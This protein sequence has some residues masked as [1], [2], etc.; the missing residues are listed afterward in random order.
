MVH[1]SLQLLR[2]QAKKRCWDSSLVSTIMDATF[3]DRRWDV[4]NR[5]EIADIVDTYPVLTY[6]EEVSLYYVNLNT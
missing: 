5:L 3:A 1:F 2:V 4:L 6:E